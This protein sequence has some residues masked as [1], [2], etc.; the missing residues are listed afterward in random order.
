MTPSVII[1]LC[2][3]ATQVLGSLITMVWKLS[4]QNSRIT[5]NE[6]D[7]ARL[8]SSQDS[9]KEI[10]DEINKNLQ[11]IST[12]IDM[13]MSQGNWTVSKDGK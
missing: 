9:I 8:E 7:I 1:S 11:S 13:L 2:S 4:K 3:L 5:Q 12:K 6:K 10:V